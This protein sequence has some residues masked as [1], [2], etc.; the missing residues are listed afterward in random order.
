MNDLRIVSF[1]PAATEMVYV[2]GLGGHLAGVS[3]E[4]DFPAAARN[5]PVVCRPALA[6]ERMSLR[7]IDI[8]VSE[9]IRRGASLYVVDEH[10][11]RQLAPT[12]II[13]QALCQVCAPS[14]NEISQALN[15]LPTKPHILWFTPRCVADI[16]ENL[17]QLGQM[18]GCPGKAEEIIA[19]NRARL[20][21]VA[22]LTR[23]VPRR[24]RWLCLK[25]TAPY[26]CS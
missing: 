12:H 17:R 3:H 8:A 21:K 22:E 25:G 2:L 15:A 16:N 23:C 26:Y 10:L 11:L 9:H 5:K 4:C 14:G 1:L 24:P 19:S 20:Q 6:L 18:A 13:T 7:E